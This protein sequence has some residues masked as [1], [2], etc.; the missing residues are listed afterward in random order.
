MN[1]MIFSCGSCYDWPRHR[2]SSS[3][4]LDT[5]PVLSSKGPEAHSLPRWICMVMHGVFFTHDADFDYPGNMVGI[6]KKHQ[7][8]SKNIK[9]LTV[10]PTHQIGESHGYGS[11]LRHPGEHHQTLANGSSSIFIPPKDS[12]NMYERDERLTKTVGFF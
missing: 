10:S 3:E 1:M 5:L 4:C 12:T 2:S 9:K 6:Y 7:K 11:K 8:T